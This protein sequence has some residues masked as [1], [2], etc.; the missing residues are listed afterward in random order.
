M[1]GKTEIEPATWK[2]PNAKASG[3]KQFCVILKGEG[4][5]LL[6]LGSLSY[7]TS[8]NRHGNIARET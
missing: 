4:K 5:K 6:F 7:S 2:V 1:T 8:E 3:I